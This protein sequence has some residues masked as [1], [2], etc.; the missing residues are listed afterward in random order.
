MFCI[1]DVPVQD[2]A[3]IQTTVG[4]KSISDCCLQKVLKGILI[5]CIYVLGNT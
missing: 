2:I 4:D 1:S 3:H 5:Q